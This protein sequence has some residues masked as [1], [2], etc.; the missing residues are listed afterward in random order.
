MLHSVFVLTLCYIDFYWYGQLFL[1]ISILVDIQNR[2][3]FMSK[4]YYSVITGTGSYIPT[5]I[6]PNKAFLANEFYDSK[7]NKL[8]KTNQE[9]IEKLEEIT[10]ITERRYVTDDL[11][12][13]DIAFLLPRKP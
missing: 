8:L 11:N 6:V 2:A 7:G 4:Q 3:F 12:T 1:E 10:T 5:E 9:I 13:S